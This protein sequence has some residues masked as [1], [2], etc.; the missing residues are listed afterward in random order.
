MED[1]LKELLDT[2]LQAEAL[3][4]EANARYQQ[5]IR[6]ARSQA[7]VTEQSFAAGLPAL[8][9]SHLQK[10]DER[11]S[12]TIA[13]LRRR[14]DERRDELRTVAE[15]REREAIEAAIDVIT[16]PARQ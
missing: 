9:Q 12:Q 1:V 13:E 8:Y 5:L 14:Y 6:E 7:Q 16:D 2:E 3:V 11:A 15:G 4:K 10:I